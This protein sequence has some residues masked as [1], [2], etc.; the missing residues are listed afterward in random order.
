MNHTTIQLFNFK[1]FFNIIHRL[2]YIV[3]KIDENIKVPLSDGNTMLLQNPTAKFEYDTS[4]EKY[5]NRSTSSVR[6]AFFM[7][8][9]NSSSRT[10]LLTYYNVYPHTQ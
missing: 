6:N 7:G 1:D 5:T 2:S 9:E 8:K 10:A 4:I 3:C